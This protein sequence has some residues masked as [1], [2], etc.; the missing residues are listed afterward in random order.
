MSLLF[1]KI[2]PGIN[3]TCLLS[4]LLGEMFDVS[5]SEVVFY[6]AEAETGKR[7]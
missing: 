2:K 6:I 3:F 1:M 7:I 4:K 5:I